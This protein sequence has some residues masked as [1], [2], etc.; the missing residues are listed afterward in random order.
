MSPTPQGEQ[1]GPQGFMCSRWMQNKHLVVAMVTTSSQEAT[2]L[3][4]LPL[5]H[6]S[7]DL[8]LWPEHLKPLCVPS[9]QIPPDSSIRLN[10]KSFRA[11]VPRVRLP[12]ALRVQ[13]E[14]PKP[15]GVF[16]K[17]STLLSAWSR[18]RRPTMGSPVK[19]GVLQV[20]LQS[21]NDRGPNPVSPGTTGHPVSYW[22]SLTI[23]RNTDKHHK[24][25][26]LRTPSNYRGCS[27][28]QALFLADYKNCL[29][30]G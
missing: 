2:L 12:L 5:P 15:S 22:W 28:G 21:Q 16:F 23:P 9:L 6:L 19:A 1:P 3:N 26:Q 13:V 7:S 10:T 17:T 20:S 27:R 25:S 11:F 18:T 4:T 14:P 24:M 30:N 29:L 8:Q